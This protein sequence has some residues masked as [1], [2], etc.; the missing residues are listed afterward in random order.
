MKR[1]KKREE[2]DEKRGRRRQR[3]SGETVDNRKPAY[4][5]F[6]ASFFAISFMMTLEEQRHWRTCGATRS[7][8]ATWTRSS[9]KSGPSPL[10]TDVDV[11]DAVGY[12]ME[13]AAAPADCPPPAPVAARDA[14]GASMEGYISCFEKQRRYSRSCAKREKGKK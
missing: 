1:K 6:F 12:G 4:L 8:D 7:L 11:D 3:A 9:G 5:V 2:V 14:A 13:D 10:A